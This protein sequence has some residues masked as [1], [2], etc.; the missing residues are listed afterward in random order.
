M[1]ARWEREENKN[2][3]DDFA[4]A[5]GAKEPVHQ[6]EF[7]SSVL[8]ALPG[9]RLAPGIQFIETQALEDADRGVNG[10]MCRAEVPLTVP[11]AIGHLLPQQVVDKRFE[12]LVVMLEVAEDGEHHAGD[13]RLAAA[14]PSV[15]DAA[16][17][18]QSAVQQQWARPARLR[19]GRGQTKVAEQQHRVGRGRPLRGV[20]SAVRRL[21][22]CPSAFA[23]LPGQQTGAP[24]LPRHLGPFPLD[25]PFASPDQ[26]PQGLPADSRIA[27][28]Q[29]SNGLVERACRICF[30]RAGAH[31]TGP[32]CRDAGI[33]QWGGLLVATAALGVS[34]CIM[35]SKLANLG[36]ENNVT[37]NAKQKRRQHGRPI[38]E[39][40]VNG[41]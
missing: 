3:L 1:P 33:D 30:H 40:L 38:T 16:I 19:V 35:R 4:R 21:A 22:A 36:S 2:R 10:R 20:Q 9:S 6:Q 15:V 13:A 34:A 32:T 17:A 18:L 26:I 11:A 27:V 39:T 5:V 8:C 31:G 25:T 37:A 24:P 14:P 12:P 7:A 29:P 23:I 41:H 28:E